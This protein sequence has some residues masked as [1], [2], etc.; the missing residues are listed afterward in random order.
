MVYCQNINPKIINDLINN[1]VIPFYDLSDGFS[2]EFWYNKA[3]SW[4]SFQ[5]INSFKKL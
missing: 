5:Y 4:V 3:G 1:S 2:F